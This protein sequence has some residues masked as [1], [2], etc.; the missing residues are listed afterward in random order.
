LQFWHFLGFLGIVFIGKVMD[1]VYGSRD[2]VWLSVHGGLM[3]MGQH[4]RFK[5]R[6]V[7]VIALRE[8]EREEVIGVLINDATWRRSCGDGHMT[9]LNRGDQWCSDGEMVLDA[10]RRDWSWSGC[11]G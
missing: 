10:R 11:G 6:E 3:A 7:V 1:L 2:H 8:R 5:A 9:A 4:D